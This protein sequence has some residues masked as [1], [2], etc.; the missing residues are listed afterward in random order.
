MENTE[1]NNYRVEFVLKWKDYMNPMKIFQA[2]SIFSKNL[3]I[4]QN[5]DPKELEIQEN[6]NT[7][8][9]T[10]KEDLNENLTKNKKDVE[11]LHWLRFNK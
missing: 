9:K 8:A 7:V 6:P 2:A 3:E 1:D 10:S 11:K 4:H 5:S